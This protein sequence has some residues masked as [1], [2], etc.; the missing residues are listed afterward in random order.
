M[1]TLFDS[2]RVSTQQRPARANERQFDYLS[3]SG[4]P[5]IAA[6]RSCLEEWFVDYPNGAKATLAAR[7]R[8]SE[9]TSALFELYV[10]T[11]LRKHGHNPVVME[12]SPHRAAKRMPDFRIELADGQSLLV[13]ATTVDC[14]PSMSKVDQDLAPL[15]SELD[16]MATP[17]RISVQI[18]RAAATP[19]AFAQFRRQIESW[20]VSP[21]FQARR[22]AALLDGSE[23]ID[24]D[25][26]VGD[27]V[28]E[29][30][31]YVSGSLGTPPAAGESPIVLWGSGVQVLNPVERLR[32]G[33]KRKAEHYNVDGPVVLAV[34]PLGLCVDRDVFAAALYGP[35]WESI[36][37]DGSSTIQ[38]KGEG[39]WYTPPRNA[40]NRSI[41]AVLICEDVHPTTLGC[42]DPVV[43]HAPDTPFPVPGLLPCATH[44]QLIELPVQYSNGAKGR[45]LLGLPAG[46]P[47]V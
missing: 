47:R 16:K 1:V 32:K 27:W 44:A 26:A 30:T 3:E 6:V 28:I 17:Q 39:L 41:P 37:L 14:C 13:E 40:R 43:Y 45:D 19:L 42:P 12:D 23:S 25:F 9:L 10:Y 35:T 36:G 34:S 8:G 2:S 4:R 18:S 29:V 11:L 21:T 33:L 46:W 20:F 5:E 7:F 15:K 38:R 31:A 22:S 24:E